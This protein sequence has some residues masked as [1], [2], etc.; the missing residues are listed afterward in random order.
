M[1]KSSIGIKSIFMVV[2]V[3]ALLVPIDVFA[4][5]PFYFAFK[6]GIY[7]PRSSDL[8]GFD[9]GFNG[10]FAFGFRF[11]PNIA[12]EFGLGY[13][14]TGGEKTVVSGTSVNQRHYDIDVWPFTLTLKAILPY[15][16]WDFFGL[17][18]G[19]IYSVS[20]PYNA[21][22]Y[23]HYPYPYYYNDYDYIWGGYLG[24]G[25]HYNITK[26]IFLGVEAKYLWTEPAKF[27]SY[28]GFKLDGIISNAVI[29]FRF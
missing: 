9:N 12:A 25:I 1:K 28:D 23:Y 14:N 17:A 15:G 21:N 6:G 8:N 3:L 20:V 24:A 16:K 5:S 2:L 27:T 11:T 22:G 4:Q 7:S 18:G 26:S 19:G 10:E 13:F 29:G